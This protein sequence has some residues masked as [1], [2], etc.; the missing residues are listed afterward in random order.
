MAAIGSWD[1]C[2]EKEVSNAL[3]TLLGSCMSVWRVTNPQIFLSPTEGD[4][5]KKVKVLANGVEMWFT[6]NDA[7]SLLIA[8]PD[9]GTFYH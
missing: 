7:K 2:D 5:A 4:A 1:S 6:E 9:T 3:E 8:V